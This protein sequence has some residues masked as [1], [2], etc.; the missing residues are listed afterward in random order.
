MPLR[1]R[2]TEISAVT[3]MKKMNVEIKERKR[4]E[5]QVA[6]RVGCKYL[7]I[8]RWLT[9]AALIKL[10]IVK[11]HTVKLV[12]AIPYVPVAAIAV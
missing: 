8:N 7:N 10:C 11:S 2:F 4:L 9:L 3:G 5:V 6:W 1:S 12:V